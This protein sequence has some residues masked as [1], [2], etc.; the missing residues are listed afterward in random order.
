ML[1][2]SEET[3]IL[4]EIASN[5]S[6]DEDIYEDIQEILKGKIK[7]KAPVWDRLN[8]E[9]FKE[10]L[11]VV[12]TRFVHSPKLLIKETADYYRNKY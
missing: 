7:D 9:K 1:N 10:K 2:S 4:N 12:M 8:I 5:V 6:I 11:T 3:L